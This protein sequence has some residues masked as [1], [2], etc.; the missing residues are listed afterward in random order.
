MW[1]NWHLNRHELAV[2][3]W[4]IALSMTLVGCSM[5]VIAR[6]NIADSPDAMVPLT[7]FTL[8]RDLGTSIN[9][10]AWFILW[11]GVLRFMGRS[12]PDM[13]LLYGAW[14]GFLAL[15][16]A[17]HPLNMPAAWAVAWISLLISILSLL[18]LNDILRHGVSGIATWFASAGFSGA[19]LTWGVR[20]VMSFLDISRPID[21]GFDTVV[22]F[23]AV[24]TTF[25]C[26]MALILLTNQRLIDR[27]GTVANLDDSRAVLSRRAFLDSVEPLLESSL[28]SQQPST[29]VLPNID[30][31]SE[32]NDKYGG[33]SGDQ[34]LAHVPLLVMRVLGRQDLLARYSGSEFI[35]F[36]YGKSA[37]QSKTLM[38]RLLVLLKQNALDTG[39]GPFQVNLSI[40]IAE[41]RF[42]EG[43]SETI[44]KAMVE[45]QQQKR[46]EI[47]SAKLA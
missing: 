17:G 21:S 41:H 36:I 46:T 33:K 1:I 8:L 31:F 12:L 23:G 20:S 34:T 7:F 38:N 13:K 32:I 44:S 19:A 30:N 16:I 22:M 29:I 15:L 37:Q 24:I 10:F 25:A 42:S 43:V 18:V 14:L 4:A 47:S 2:R 3:D 40:G 11:R 45:L 6:L 26:M 5:A 27:F 35:L 28:S 9:G 39:R